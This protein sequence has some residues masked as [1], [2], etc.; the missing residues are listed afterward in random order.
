MIDVSRR[1]ALA[2]LGAGMCLLASRRLVAHAAM[3]PDHDPASSAPFARP[4]R[5]PGSSGLLAELRLA[6]P[7]EFT[8]RVDVLPVFSGHA[9]SVWNYAAIIDG[10]VLNDPL[11]IARRGD[12]IDATLV[13][14]LG[15]DTTIHWHGLGNDEANDGS[16]LHPVRHG[17]RYRYAFEVRNR[18][19]LSWYHA[20]PHFRTGDQVHHGL[21]SLLLVEDAEELALRERLGIPWSERDIPLLLADKQLGRNN[22]ITYKA[23][24]DDWIGNRVLVNWT[25]EPHL[26]VHRATYRLRIANVSNARMF[27][28]AFVH[29]GTPLRYR[30]IG[31]DGGLLERPFETTQVYL[32]PAQRVDLL[33][34]LS[35]LRAGDTVRMRSLAYDP[36]END[37]AAAGED[38]MM[39]H[40]GAAPMGAR[41]DLME[42]R[43]TAGPPERTSVPKQLAA[44]LPDPPRHAPVSRS[45]RIRISDSGRWMINDWNFLLQPHTHAPA[46]TVRRGNREVWEFV[47]EFR[48]MPH[49]IHLHGFQFRVLER[50]KS[51]SQLRALVVADGGRTAQD[52]G[53][54]DTVVVWPGERV[55]IAIDFAQPF[56]GAQTYMLHCHNLEHEDQG[57]M[58]AFAVVD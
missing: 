7:L 29:R 23:G 19:G 20:H 34:D 15:Q 45:F 46:F 38:P 44:P 52:M 40:P 28:L 21:A 24:A 54:L 51:P 4:L 14:Q 18:A 9:T 12:T 31:T 17:G 33:L 55:R 10:R 2:R 22:E 25:P 37:A 27:K 57:M 11:L 26:D 6:L 13:N 36:M 32:A 41:M 1:G 53:L 35:A 8:A 43:V 5:R 39:E 58:V 42:F 16:G 47:N 49:P 50:R 48:S 30:L 3:A 56:R